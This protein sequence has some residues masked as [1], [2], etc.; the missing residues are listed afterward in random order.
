MLKPRLIVNVG[1]KHL[2]WTANYQVTASAEAPAGSGSCIGC[3]WDYHRE[4]IFIV[5]AEDHVDPI[6]H[7]CT[8]AFKKMNF[9]VTW[10]TILDNPDFFDPVI[11]SAS[12]SSSDDD[13][14]VSEEKEEEK[15]KETPT[16]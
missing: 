8:W 2:H 11:S 9:P 12:S 3:G 1:S 6:W 15:E 13:S 14:S 16:S 5:T 4:Q 10:R 7:K